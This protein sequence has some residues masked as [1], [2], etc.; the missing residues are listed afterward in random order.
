[1]KTVQAGTERLRDVDA[2]R[3]SLARVRQVRSALE[4]RRV[5][6]LGFATKLPSDEPSGDVWTV[7]QLLR[8]P[9][10]VEKVAP[11]AIPRL[12]GVLRTVEV[13]LLARL[14]SD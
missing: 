3:R 9:T 10:R 1:M 13:S 2:V 7:M 8:D 12:L 4:A 6:M 11:E 5:V 14:T